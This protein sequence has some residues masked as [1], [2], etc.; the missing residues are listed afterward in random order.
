MGLWLIW[1][2]TKQRKEKDGL[3]GLVAAGPVKKLGP[4][5]PDA[6]DQDP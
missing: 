6:W 1:E 4:R 2:K 3:A 5:E